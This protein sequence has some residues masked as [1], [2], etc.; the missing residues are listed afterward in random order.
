MNAMP[1]RQQEYWSRAIFKAFRDASS[2]EEE[3]FFFHWF[4]NFKGVETKYE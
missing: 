4:W 3:W 1:Q 2:D